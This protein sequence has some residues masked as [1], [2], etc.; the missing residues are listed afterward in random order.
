MSKVNVGITDRDILEIINE[1]YDVN[2]TI[3]NKTVVIK[4]RPLSAVEFGEISSSDKNEFDKMRDVLN[5]VIV[6]PETIKNKKLPVG[7]VI[8]AY[9][10]IIDKSFLQYKLGTE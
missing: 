6:Q 4:C 3:A 1:V 9:N 5:M 10:Q 7:F 8:S 2:I